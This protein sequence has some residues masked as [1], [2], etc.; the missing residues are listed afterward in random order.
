MYKRQRLHTL[1]DAHHSHQDQLGYIGDDSID[2]YAEMCIRDRYVKA[3][4]S[5]E[6]LK[7]LSSPVAKVIRNGQP[8]EIDASDLVCG[9]IVRLEAGDVVP[10][11]GRMIESYSLKVNESSLTGESEG[12]DKRTEVIDGDA[13]ALGDQINICLLYTSRLKV[14]TVSIT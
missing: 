3:E 1:V 9:D 11:D 5:L 10:G 8:Q 14:M 13:V 6:S 7:S 12:V 2:D 4:K